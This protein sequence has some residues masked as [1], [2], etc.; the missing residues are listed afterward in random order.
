M[1]LLCR[2]NMPNCGD[3]LLPLRGISL[4]KAQELLNYTLDSHRDCREPCRQ[5]PSAHNSEHWERLVHGDAGAPGCLVQQSA[6]H[7]LLLLVYWQRE[8]FNLLCLET[9]FECKLLPGRVCVRLLSC[10]FVS[11]G[12][13]IPQQLQ[14]GILNKLK[15][16]F[17]GRN[18]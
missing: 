17:I 4:C 3:P 11:S 18:T 2:N 15:T 1:Y 6:F 14:Q 5:N 8:K 10:V 13:E 16:L 12:S 7:P 9:A